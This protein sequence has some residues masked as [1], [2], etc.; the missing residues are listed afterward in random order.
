MAC[1]LTKETGGAVQFSG[2]TSN[3]VQI[4]VAGK[5]GTA[6]IISARYKNTQLAK[7]WKFKIK[8]GNNLLVVLV[9]DTLPGDFVKLSEVCAPGVT[10]LMRQFKYNPA[11]PA[12][13]YLIQGN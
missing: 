1:N 3:D 12:R 9:E 13:G 6:K 7:P 2:Q 10:K 8:S 11:N 5:Q 4:T